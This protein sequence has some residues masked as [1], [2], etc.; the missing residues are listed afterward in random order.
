MLFS[1][2]IMSVSLKNILVVLTLL[3]I[4]K[5]D[6]TNVLPSADTMTKVIKYKFYISPFAEAKYYNE[7]K[8]VEDL[9]NFVSSELER[10][11][12][13]YLEKSD[14][15]TTIVFEPLF[16][17]E[18]P[19]N[20]E[21][22]KCDTNLIELA[23]ILNNLL[24]E[25]SDTSVI[26]MFSCPSLP[27]KDTFNTTGQ[28]VPYITHELSPLC[29]TRTLLFMETEQPKFLAAVSTALM[30]A[31]GVNVSNPLMFEE[32]SNGDEG[33]RFDIRVSNESMERIKENRCFYNH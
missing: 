32:V 26:A 27:Y 3:N 12:N 21:L 15:P 28:E 14:R 2:I 19:P 13:L 33:V 23:N 17:K 18:I 20:I 7:G 1:K 9:V 29:T 6:N 10:A 22:D 30:R 4:F 24:M 8:N 25:T 11:L 16:I 5:C 31:A